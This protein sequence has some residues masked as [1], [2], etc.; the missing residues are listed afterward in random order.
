MSDQ[1][2]TSKA[3]NQAQV[4]VGKMTDNCCDAHLDEEVRFFCKDCNV[5]ICDECVQSIHKTHDFKSFK[6]VVKE[7][8]EKEAQELD[9][10][11]VSRVGFSEEAE[12]D[13]INMDDTL[14]GEI[15]KLKAQAEKL[16]NK[17]NQ[18][19]DQKE[20][21]I[22]NMREKNKIALQQLSLFV[23]ELFVEPFLELRKL[24]SEPGRTNDR[25][26]V[27]IIMRLE[28]LLNTPDKR[29]QH[30]VFIPTFVAAETDENVV[31]KLFGE[32][33]IEERSMSKAFGKNMK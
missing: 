9:K 21:E 7:F 15:T 16:V 17:I 10:L 29:L 12:Q 11:P 8:M 32:F 24:I 5:L 22:Q 30:T 33:E 13:R 14:K 19:R 3:T 6:K 20:R 18:I 26:A 23:E 31:E 27:R 1:K 25:E 28:D 4:Q 2:N